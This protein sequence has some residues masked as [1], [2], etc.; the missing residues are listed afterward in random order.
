MSSVTAESELLTITGGG[1]G[2]V[3]GYGASV[4][5]DFASVPPE[6]TSA[7]MYSGP[8]SG[9]MLAA[10]MA[11][12]G[13][14][15]E[16]HSAA[17]SY[18]AVVSGLTDGPWLGASSAAMAAATAPYGVWL[19]ATAARAEQT[20]AQARMAAA[21]YET[22]FAATV[23][24]PV[25][26]A[27]R[28]LLTSLVA[29][30]L[31]GQNAPAIAATESQ[32]VA[33]WAQDAAAMYGYAGE[34]ASAT[35][36]TPFTPPPPSVDPDGLAAQ[37]TNV[38]EAAGTSAA[39]HTETVLSQLTSAVP[40]VLKGLATPLESTAPAIPAAAG[41][42]PGVLDL[43]GVLGITPLGTPLGGVGTG[44]TSAAW[45]SASLASTT[46]QDTRLR[47]VDVGDMILNRIDEFETRTAMGSAGLDI[48]GGRSVSAGLGQAPSLGGLAVPQSWATTAPAIKTVAAVLSTSGLG[49][50][51]AGLAA[52]QVSLLS[53][54]AL[55]S[56][57]GR[58]VGGAAAKS[59]GPGPGAEGLAARSG[60]PVT[61]AALLSL[62]ERALGTTPST[63]RPAVM[64]RP[65]AAG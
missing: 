54:L 14:A 46:G 55:A 63:S 58:A 28:S 40:T 36:L 51:S 42:L 50:P 62:V 4:A 27:N 13:L 57:A 19:S 31:F 37:A 20:A 61:E 15:A 56:V 35:T 32:Y 26:A 48:G 18:R 39:T 5:M 34:S 25:I 64:G 43:L 22:A 53:Q 7:L 11:W 59:T 29:T 47:I 44:I 30:N 23:P 3:I 65:P 21:A 17:G 45:A 12:D 1:H 38:A 8:G 41:G 49:A 10:A 33:M 60:S 24:P 6:I 52:G 16:L 9:S 2:T